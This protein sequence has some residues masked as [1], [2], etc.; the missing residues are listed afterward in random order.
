MLALGFTSAD[1]P[2]QM[3]LVRFTINWQLIQASESFLNPISR[4]PIG[5]IH[6]LLTVVHPMFYQLM[7][8]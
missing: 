7:N 5:R 1:K 8:S 2:T 6:S 3:S 4:S